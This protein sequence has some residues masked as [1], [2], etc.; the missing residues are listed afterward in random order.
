MALLGTLVYLFSLAGSV[1]LGY[2]GNFNL[3]I[4]LLLPIG[5][6]CG[7]LIRRG[8]RSA[9]LFRSNG[10]GVLVELFSRYA[11][12]LV[13]CGIGFGIGMGILEIM[14]RQPVGY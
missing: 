14:K 10:F 12:G 3:A 8:S 7:E 5:M 1:Y 9:S 4:L 2:H 11:V 13:L 6:M